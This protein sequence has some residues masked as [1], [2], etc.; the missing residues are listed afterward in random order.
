[1]IV[2]KLK[3]H[4]NIGK[5]Y[6]ETLKLPPKILVFPY[7]LSETLHFLWTAPQALK[8]AIAKGIVNAIFAQ[9]DLITYVY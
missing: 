5:S 4:L 9:E 1:M 6:L 3:I 8:F 7:G 2:R